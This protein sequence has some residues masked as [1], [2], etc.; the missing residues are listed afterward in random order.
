MAWVNKAWAF[1]TTNYVGIIAVC[2]LV[3]SVLA[4]AFQVL[5][6][7]AQRENDLL[8]REGA[9]LQREHDLLLMKPV[10]RFYRL[11]S[12]IEATS[13]MGLFIENVGGGP[14]IMTSG[15][16]K[17]QTTGPIAAELESMGFGG[18]QPLRVLAAFLKKNYTPT[19]NIHYALSL[20]DYLPAGTRRCLIGI[21][22]SSSP[23]DRTVFANLIQ[24]LRIEIDYKSEYGQTDSYTVE[25]LLVFQDSGLTSENAEE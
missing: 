17:V 11:L 8:Q 5:E 21:D 14:A 25:P 2:A 6:Y 12:S 3:I 20:T 19:L 7:R 9:R 16:I 22:P 23:S 10:V 1:L 13:L 24:A 4:V 18:G 15:S